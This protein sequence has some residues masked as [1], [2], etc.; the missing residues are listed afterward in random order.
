ML[1]RHLPIVVGLLTTLTLISVMMLIF[2]LIGFSRG[3]ALYLAWLT[4]VIG[5]YFYTRRMLHKPG[6]K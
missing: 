1:N 2:R 6:G 3:D 4:Y 5:L